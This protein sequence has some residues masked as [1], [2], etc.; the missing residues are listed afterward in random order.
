MTDAERYLYELRPDGVIAGSRERRRRI[1]KIPRTAHSGHVSEVEPDSFFNRALVRGYIRL[2]AGDEP[3]CALLVSN[4]E[5]SADP[6]QHVLGI[7][8]G[9]LI[10]EGE[11]V[12]FTESDTLETEFRPYCTLYRMEIRGHTV[13]LEASLYGE[14]GICAVAR[15]DG[16]AVEL[17][18]GGYM[19]SGRTFSASYIARDAK[20]IRSRISGSNGDYVAEPDDPSFDYGGRPP[21]TE[22][23]EIHFRGIN[24]R[25]SAYDGAA[26]AIADGELAFSTVCIRGDLSACDS[27]ITDCAASEAAI[28]SERAYYSGLLGTAYAKTPS[29]ALDAGFSCNIAEHD[30]GYV[31]NAWYEGVHWWNCYWT[32]NYQISAAVSLGQYERA[33]RALRFF[34][35][36]ESGYACTDASGRCAKH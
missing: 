19:F 6:Y 5:P 18:F 10:T 11:R 31:G 35:G 14:G 20:V 36:N 30:R 22:R 23:C 2:A 1:G 17:S 3:E 7:L 29:A 28:A 25:S 4:P 15:S 33:A 21:V 34:G 16:G 26:A 13:T 9:A 32:N 24:M 12:P 27:G 8:R